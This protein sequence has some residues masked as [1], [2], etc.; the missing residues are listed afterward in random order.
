MPDNQS[1]SMP[2]HRALVHAG[3]SEPWSMPDHQ[4]QPNADLP[5]KRKGPCGPLINQ[6]FLVL[7]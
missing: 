6:L 4:K 1:W 2:D 5:G 7:G 3:P